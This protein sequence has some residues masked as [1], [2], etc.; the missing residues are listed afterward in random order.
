MSY[1]VALLN[2][3]GP[4]DLLM[5]LIERSQLKI[6]EIALSDIT[7]QY[8]T[9]I[10]QLEDLDPLELNQF[11]ELASKLMFIK[12]RELIP[13]LSPDET[14][15]DIETELSQQLNRYAHY[16]K[17]AAY[18]EHLLSRGQ[19]TWNRPAPIIKPAVPPPSNLSLAELESLFRQALAHQQPAGRVQIS[20]LPKTEELIARIEQANDQKI[21]FGELLASA[22]SRLELV[23]LFS[24]L[25]ELLKQQRISVHQE[26]QFGDII[27]NK[28]QHNWN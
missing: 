20:R 28:W 25:L 19:Q 8:L 27:I 9:Y 18:L 22:H 10:E 21:S 7:E 11:V 16:R 15:A 23:M 17:A 12:S 2:F 26:S 24:V 13:T 4:L 5:Q 6:T 1:Q 14:E 3:E